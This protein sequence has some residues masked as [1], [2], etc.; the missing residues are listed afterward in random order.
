[1]RKSCEKKDGTP[2]IYGSYP[3]AYNSWLIALPAELA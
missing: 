1:M 2:T 3:E